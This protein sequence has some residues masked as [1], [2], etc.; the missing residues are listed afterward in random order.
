[1]PD[2]T[3][4]PMAFASRTL[5]PSE[6]NYSQVEKEALSLIFGI[7]HFHYYLC[8]RRFTVVTDHKPLLSILGP[9]KAIPTMAAARLQRWAWLLSSYHYE[10]EFRNTSAHANA[11]GL[12]CLPLNS[13]PEPDSSDPKIFNL[14]QMEALP[15]TDSVTINN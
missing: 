10:I 13:P 8:G 1:M 3:E 9:K 6:K 15:V 12:S 7:K 2:G 4:H 5:T 14:S 11:D